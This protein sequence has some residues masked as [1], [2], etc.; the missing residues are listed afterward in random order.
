MYLYLAPVPSKQNSCSHQA[1]EQNN[2]YDLLSYSMVSTIPITLSGGYD[3]QGSRK[4]N[5]QNHSTLNEDIYL[6][7]DLKTN[8][9]KSC[10]Y[11]AGE[12]YN[13]YQVSTLELPFYNYREVTISRSYI[14]QGSCK[15]YPLDHSTLYKGIYLFPDP[16]TCMHNNRLQQAGE[17]NSLYQ[18]SCN[19]QVSY[20]M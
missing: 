17:H 13:F 18:V 3:D 6:R 11:Q 10:L 7:V 12:R 15:N 20:I 19:F 9:N 5:S 14:D 2:P 16:S 8:I 1:L 4:M